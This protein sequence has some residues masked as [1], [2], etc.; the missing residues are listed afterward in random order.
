MIRVLQIISDTN[1]GG[2]GRVLSNYLSAW[3]Q[4][5]FQIHI[6]VPEQS[7]LVEVFTPMGATVHKVKGMADRSYHK[8]DVA[9]LR[10]LIKEVQPDLIHTHGAFSGRVAGKKEGVPV[11]FSRHSVFPVSWKK[12]YPPMRWVNGWLNCHYADGMIAVSPAA[13]DNLVELGVP[14]HCITTIFNGVSSLTEVNAPEKEAFCLSLGIPKE[15]FLF[16]ILARL[17][18]YK[19]HQLLLDACEELKRRGKECTVLIAGTGPE[20]E[21]IKKEIVARNLDDMVLFL[22]F[23]QEIPTLLSVIDVQVNCSFGTEATSIALLEGM[24]LGVPAVVSDYGGNPA[25]IAHQGN[26]LVYPSLD[27]DGLVQGMCRMMEDKELYARCQQGAKDI[28]HQK[29]TAEVFAKETEQYYQ[30]ILEQKK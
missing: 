26:G 18:E 23:C 2:A 19:G 20:E 16:G 24:S 22:G 29:F 3:N 8:E 11:I 15:K 21:K 25:V 30:Q 13:V 10:K 17:E 27:K 1:L 6:A 9:Q 28:F 12:K 5:Q 7:V 4:E 14:R